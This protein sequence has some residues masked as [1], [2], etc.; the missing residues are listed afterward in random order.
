M[1]YSHIR[2]LHLLNCVSFLVKFSTKSQTRSQL[3]WNIY[4]KWRHT[5]RTYILQSKM[6]P[7]W[8]PNNQTARQ[9]VNA[10]NT[11]LLMLVCFY[12]LYWLNYLTHWLRSVLCANWPLCACPF[13]LSN[14]SAYRT[15][16][17]SC[18]GHDPL[19]SLCIR[20]CLTDVFCG[21]IVHFCT[22]ENRI[23]WFINWEA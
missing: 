3:T 10:H 8:K 4:R 12:N 15:W 13:S 14:S 9:E 17:R 16:A 5:L 22:V 11:S 21:R 20:H 2:H 6:R 23:R 19:A 1:F 18:R 7:R